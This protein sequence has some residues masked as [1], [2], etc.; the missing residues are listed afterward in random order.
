[1]ELTELENILKVYDKRVA[2]NTRLNREVLK[3]ILTNKAEKHLNKEK[4]RGGYYVV[5]PFILPFILY[6]VITITG[7]KISI[8]TNFYIGLCLFIPTYI[9]IYIWNVKYY[10]LV[11]K[12]DYAESILSI[13]KQITKLEKCKLKATSIR[14]LFLPMLILGALLMVMPKIIF[15]TELIIMLTLITVVF[16][17]S[18][19]YMKHI[20]R[21]RFKAFKKELEDIDS[22]GV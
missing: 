9:Y 11:R 1:M 7:I 5:S 20:D 14:N 15:T 18:T 16:I 19:Y 12:I 6:L 22:L 10:L 3:K 21:E 4:I 17:V 2:E 8:C 13:K